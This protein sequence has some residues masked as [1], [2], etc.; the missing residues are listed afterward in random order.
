MVPSAGCTAT[1][2]LVATVNGGAFPGDLL[3]HSI[4]HIS[5]DPLDAFRPYGSNEQVQELV[6]DVAAYRVFASGVR[7]ESISDPQLHGVAD[8]MAVGVIATF[9]AVKVFSTSPPASN[10]AE[11]L[12]REGHG[13]AL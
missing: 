6:A 8:S 1:P 11:R 10:S 3:R 7:G 13:G 2:M 9:E 5:C 4:R 12:L